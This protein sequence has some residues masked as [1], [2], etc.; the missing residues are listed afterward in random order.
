MTGADCSDTVARIN[1]G[2]VNFYKPLI[3]WKCAFDVLKSAS[4]FGIKYLVLSQHGWKNVPSPSLK[5]S[6]IQLENVLTSFPVLSVEAVSDSGVSIGLT[7]SPSIPSSSWW[8]GIRT[9]HIIH[10]TLI[11]QYNAKTFYDGDWAELSHWKLVC[12]LPHLFPTLFACNITPTLHP[13]TKAVAW[14][15]REGTCW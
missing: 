8:G 9:L 10:T 14:S 5:I 12:I 6:V 13:L 1:V 2:T 7:P 11:W 15:W 4:C 3:C